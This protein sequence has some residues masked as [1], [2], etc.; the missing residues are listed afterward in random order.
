MYQAEESPYEPGRFRKYIEIERDRRETLPTIFYAQ[1][2]LHGIVLF[3]GR[4]EYI[5]NGFMLYLFSPRDFLTGIEFGVGW[6][7]VARIC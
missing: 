4:D 7:E 6:I 5:R 2:P 1:I 3:L